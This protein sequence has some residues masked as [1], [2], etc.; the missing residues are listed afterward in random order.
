MDRFTGTGSIRLTRLFKDVDLRA[1]GWRFHRLWSTNWFNDPDA[2][3][4]RLREAY[5][6]AVACLPAP[7]AGSPG[8]NRRP[9]GPPGSPEAPAASR[10]PSSPWTP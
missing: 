9:P 10:A 4:A 7:R 8:R 1:D 6:K 3:V 2:E 5:D